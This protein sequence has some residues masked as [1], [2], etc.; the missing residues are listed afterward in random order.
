VTSGAFA[1]ERESI[2]HG[3]GQIL[4]AADVS[5][6][7]LDR[8]VPQQ[9]LDLFQFAARGVTQP[10]AGP[11]EVVGCQRR[12]SSS[13]RTSF[14][15]VPD[16]IPRDTGAH[17]VPFFLIERNSLPFEIEAFSVQWSTAA[18]TQAGTGTVRTWPALPTK[19]TIAQWSS[20]F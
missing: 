4:L 2:V 19:S 1:R 10:C 16:H 5:L 15:N 13:G 12:D 6:G 7:G 3:T 8:G 14:H 17:T 20:R 9:E 18:F 11:P